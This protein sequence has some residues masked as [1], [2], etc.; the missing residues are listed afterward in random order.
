MPSLGSTSSPGSSSYPR[1]RFLQAIETK[2]KSAKKKNE[3]AKKDAEQQFGKVLAA[4]GGNCIESLASEMEKKNGIVD[5][6]I[7]THFCKLDVWYSMWLRS[8]LWVAVGSNWSFMEAEIVE[9]GDKPHDF[10]RWVLEMEKE[11]GFGKLNRSR[12]V[13]GK[14]EGDEEGGGAKGEARSGGGE[15]GSRREAGSG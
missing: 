11:V 4:A 10:L 12:R 6:Q 14:R 3:G 9:S 8:R 13:R 7:G 2:S 1:A 5:I 15:G